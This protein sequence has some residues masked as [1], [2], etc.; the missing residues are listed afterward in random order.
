MDNSF[1]ARLERRAAECDSLL[2]VGLDPHPG[3]PAAPTAAAAG[4][5][6]LDLIE[7]LAPYACAF[8]PNSAF[9]EALGAEGWSTLRD[10]IAAVP[11]D[12]PVI[13]DAKRGDIASTSQAYARAAFDWLGADALTA[14]P[15]LGS[16]SLE[17][18]L[19]RPERGLFVLCKTSNRGADTF[20]GLEL[21]GGVPLYLEIAR[22]VQGWSRHNNLGL[23]VAAN[24]PQA[25]G[26]VR[27]SAPN[28][29]FLVPGVGAQGAELEAAVEAGLRADGS[30][31][32]VNVSRSLASAPDP[33]AAAAALRD[34]I[35]R[36]RRRP[37]A[38]RHPAHADAIR[39]AA[40]L[41]EAESVRFGSF[42]LKSG[43]QSALYLDLRKL[44]SC[45][46]ALRVAARLL[47]GRLGELT[48]D[49]LAAV[50]YAALPIATALALEG[51]WPLIFPR[52]EAKGYGTGAVVEGVY[53]PGEVALVVD[54]L[55]TTGES[56]LET[57]EKLRAAGL[58][59]QDVLVLIDRSHQA[60]AA[61]E[62]AAANCR[63]HAVATLPELLPA[64]RDM[65]VVTP[66]QY[67]AV[68]EE[69]P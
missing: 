43:R 9:F 31:V 48:F 64:W 49:R 50:P 17:P 15:Y 55:I 41:W 52:R 40:A 35:N 19:A 36:V 60:A 8:K 6:C 13:L 20:Q 62:L 53:H 22:R 38:D 14:S 26:R 11:D 67:Q 24:D 25:L 4:R 68:M 46:A 51:N 30:G 33:A 12:I 5:F 39:L 2:C 44:A 7:R 21:L 34:A 18:L 28:L 63:L 54:D 10:V 65:G 61:G 42:T 69:L 45:P 23:V 66:D 56:K 32:L 37:I 57:I 3:L 1:C 58:R 16:D 29:W 47:A 27:A 59:V